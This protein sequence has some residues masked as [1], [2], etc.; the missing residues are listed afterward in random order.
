MLRVDRQPRREL[1]PAAIGSLAQQLDLGPRRLRV[2]V[3]DRSPARRRPSRRSRRRAGAAKSSVR[4]G[5]AWTCDARAEHDPGA[6]R[7]SRAAP[8]AAARARSAIRVPGLARKFWTITSW[9]CPC[10]ARAAIARSASSRSARV[11]PIPIRIPVV[12]GT[13]SLAG[14]PERL[15]PARP[16][17]CRASR[18]AGRRAPRAARRV[19]SSIIPIDAAAGRSA[20]SSSRGQHAGVQVRQQP[21]LLEHRLARRAEVLERRRAAELGEL[22]ARGAVAQLGLVAER[23]ERLAAAR[24]RARPR[25]REHLV[26]RHVRALAAPRRLRERAV[27]ADVAAELR[28]RDEDLRAV[29]DER[30]RSPGAQAPRLGHELVEGRAKK[31]GGEVCHRRSVVAGRSPR[32]G[33]ESIRK[34]PTGRIAR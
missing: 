16:A 17:A 33:A 31:L 11:S 10:P 18:S 29:G 15:E 7:S 25:D 28:Q 12:N 5:G 8:R 1:E 34:R 32:A 9:T 3:V 23:E 19:V 2:D 21:R 26:D 24:R 30:A 27:V 13:A 14:E 4:F 20:A 6:A 22:L